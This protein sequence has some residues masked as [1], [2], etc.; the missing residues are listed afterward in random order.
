MFIYTFEI[1]DD[2][3]L[4]TTGSFHYKFNNLLSTQNNGTVFSIF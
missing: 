3:N 1:M 2:A 4:L